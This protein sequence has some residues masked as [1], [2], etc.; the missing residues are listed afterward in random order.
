MLGETDVVVI[1]GGATGTAVLWDLA[2][3]GIE[4]VLVDRSDLGTGTSG[5]WHGELHSG[6]RYAVNDLP[7][8]REC[9]E[10][11]AV[12][13]RIAP[14]TIE[15]TGGFF[16]LLPEHDLGYGDRFVTGCAETGVPCEEVDPAAARREEPALTDRI[17][18]A[19]WV[20]TDG[21]MDSWRLLWSMASGAEA[22]GGRVLVRHPVVGFERDGDGRVSAVRVHDLVGG[23]GRTIGCRW[24]INAAGA[25]AGRIGAMA[26]APFR[27]VPDMGVMVVMAGRYVRSLV[28]HCRMP[29]D[30]DIIVPAY[31]AAI[32]GTTSSEADDP[33]DSGVAPLEIDLIIDQTAKLVPAIAH[34]RALRA[35]SGYRPLYDP[36]EGE[37][38]GHGR[39]V[40]RTFT[41]LD[42][43]PGDGVPNLLS[44]VGGKLTT[45]RQ[46]AQKVVDVMV[47]KRGEERPCMTAIT[48]LP[49]AEQ[50][51]RQPTRPLARPPAGAGQADGPLACECEL[52]TRRT[53]EEAVGAGVTQLDDL[54]RQYRLGFGPTQGGGCGWRA[55]AVVAARR[56]DVGDPLANLRLFMQERWRGLRAVAWGQAAAQALR[57][58]AIYRGI[59]AL[60]TVEREPGEDKQIQAAA[61]GDDWSGARQAGPGRRV[62]GEGL[63]GDTEG[64]RATDAGPPGGPRGPLPEPTE[65]GR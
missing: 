4:A 14:H 52:I 65:G 45:S 26:G 36:V 35:Y 38:G 42:H 22:R 41:V 2:L 62:G 34:G 24:V 11:N 6:A 16:I 57:N 53:I 60:D 9:V 27:M 50:G 18:R 17:E 44:I 25:W 39:S 7:S 10:E 43:E 28:T 51:I 47:A 59:L 46:M 3:R 5:R 64:R 12:L 31:D 33:D 19:F 23:R 55:A 30:G 1:G 49:G 56:P 40:S 61:T 29:T 21:S 54:R 48:P 20:P 15:D 63:T 37:A 13:R 32:L 58:D 8:A